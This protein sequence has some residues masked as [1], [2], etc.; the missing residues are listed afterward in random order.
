MNLYFC[1]GFLTYQGGHKRYLYRKERKNYAMFA[2][3]NI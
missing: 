3:V 1:K 2:S